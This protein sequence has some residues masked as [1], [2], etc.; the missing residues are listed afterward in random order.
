MLKDALSSLITNQ[1]KQQQCKL[2][3][4]ICSLDDEESELLIGALKSEVSTMSLI[5]TLKSE[6]IN[7]S[8]EYLGEKRN[9]FKNS[10]DS[11]TCCI[12]ERLQNDK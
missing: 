5:R 1:S 2:G 7:L 4:L 9:C 8:R 6:G 11:K 10:E 3:K 12:A